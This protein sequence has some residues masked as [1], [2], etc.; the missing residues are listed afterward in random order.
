MHEY[1][2]VG[3]GP[4][5]ATQDLAPLFDTAIGTD[6][7]QAMIEVARS[8]DYKAKNGPIHFAVAAGEDFDLPGLEPGSVDLITSAMAAHWFDMAKFWKGAA[9]AL[10]PGDPST[11]NAAEVQEILHDLEY[12]ILGPYVVPGNKISQ[13]MY[14]NL[15]LPWQVDPPVNALQIESFRRIEWNKGGQC[16]DGKDF[17]V[18]NRLRIDQYEKAMSTASMV[19]RWREA[20][21]E[22]VGT[23]QDCVKLTITRL[24]KVMDGKFDF[25][26]GAGVV[27][28][29]FKKTAS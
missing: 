19:T 9:T 1:V 8:A 11:P 24:K 28:L 21:P 12:N 6:H 20:H 22:A 26:I 2:D 3:C 16:E 13:S 25:Q 23:D 29:L 7:S 27:L 14:E 5:K 18:G 15:K 4:G 17:L 10:Q